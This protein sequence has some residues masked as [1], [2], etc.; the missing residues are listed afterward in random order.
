LKEILVEYSAGVFFNF[1]DP[2]TQ[3]IMRGNVECILNV[4]LSLRVT[5]TISF[6]ATEQNEFST[7]NIYSH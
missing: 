6:A 1:N 7:R 5:L 4:I 3:S 2:F